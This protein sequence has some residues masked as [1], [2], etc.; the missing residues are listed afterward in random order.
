MHSASKVTSG[1]KRPRST[2]IAD[3]N[4]SSHSGIDILITGQYERRIMSVEDV[5]EDD[6]DPDNDD[7]DQ[8]GNDCGD[9]GQ[10]SAQDLKD[11]PILHPSYRDSISHVIHFMK[12]QNGGVIYAVDYQSE[13]QRCD[14]AYKASN[15]RDFIEQLFDFI[16]ILCYDRVQVLGTLKGMWN[17]F[18]IYLQLYNAIYFIF[19]VEKDILIALANFVPDIISNFPKSEENR[20]LIFDYFIN[21]STGLS[22]G[23][24]PVEL[25]ELIEKNKKSNV[26]EYMKSRLS[27]Q[28]NDMS[29]EEKKTLMLGKALKIRADSV[30]SWITEYY[31]R[32]FVEEGKLPSGYTMLQFLEAMRQVLIP[33]AV[34]KKALKN[35][36][37]H[38]KDDRAAWATRCES[39]YDKHM[40]SI[41]KESYLPPAWVPCI[42]GGLPRGKRCL[43]SMATTEDEVK[44]KTI[45]Q[46]RSSRRAERLIGA[47]IGRPAQLDAPT[48]KAELEVKEPEAFKH[49]HT[50]VLNIS[51]G[52]PDEV[53]LKQYEA[54]LKHQRNLIDLFER[55]GKNISM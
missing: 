4:A 22:T 37:R 6:D 16:A 21:D 44:D 47:Q 13:F 30:R 26:P 1:T 55:L 28:M 2:S 7:L 34:H 41:K 18:L 8:N 49:L 24:W 52:N 46:S 42:I 36:K 53:R 11:Y 48:K 25:I 40:K 33:T 5:K 17:C 3:S 12:R 27:T 31:N 43:P 38:L 51:S 20:Q 9:G 29:I 14:I 23:T 39:L 54:T 15:D 19:N 50:H 10:V 45:F 35:S 32:G